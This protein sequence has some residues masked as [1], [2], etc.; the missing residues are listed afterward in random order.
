MNAGTPIHTV[1]EALARVDAF[2]G[3]ADD[4]L[5]PIH[6]SL[7]DP[8]GINMALITDR[9]LAKGW[10]PDGIIVHA[11]CRVFRYKELE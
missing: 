11:G 4:F 3:S 10:E 8:L 1:A 2:A 7:L 6:E 9:I 5:L